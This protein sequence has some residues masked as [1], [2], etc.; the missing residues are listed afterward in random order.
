MVTMKG[1]IA[2][3]KSLVMRYMK[4]IFYVDFYSEYYLL[5]T[6]DHSYLRLGIRK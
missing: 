6:K 2:L 5:D 4:C 1:D 3:I